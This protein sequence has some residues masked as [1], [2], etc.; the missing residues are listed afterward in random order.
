MLKPKLR[1]GVVWSLIESWSTH[2]STNMLIKVWR[3]SYF[4]ITIDKVNFFKKT[5]SSIST[6]ADINFCLVKT[7]MAS[8]VGDSDTYHS[9]SYTYL[10]QQPCNFHLSIPLAMNDE[11]RSASLFQ[12]ARCGYSVLILSIYWISEAVPLAV[13]SL[14]PLVLF[15]LVRMGL[16]LRNSSWH[17]CCLD[18]CSHCRSGST[19]LW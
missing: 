17:A 18:R 6:D 3:L 9:A 1:E 19:S 12:Q 11:T 2:I 5:V 15:P 4:W 8:F 7:T 14:L 10:D 16:A 13:T